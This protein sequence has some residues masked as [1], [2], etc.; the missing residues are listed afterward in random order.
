MNVFSKFA[1]LLFWDWNIFSSWKLKI[2]DTTK[3]N[4]IPLKTHKKAQQRRKEKYQE[5]NPS[6]ISIK[7]QNHKE[8]KVKLSGFSVLVQHRAPVTAFILDI[9]QKP[10]V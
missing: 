9:F 8:N 10:P 7:N 4:S 2:R 1:R 5:K 6:Q 3:K